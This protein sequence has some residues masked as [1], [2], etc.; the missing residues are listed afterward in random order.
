MGSEVQ[1]SKEKKVEGSEETAK[2][3][4]KKMLGRKRAE[5]NTQQMNPKLKHEIMRPLALRQTQRRRSDRGKVRRSVSSS[6]SYHQGTSS[7]QHDDDDDDDDFET[8]RANGISD[9]FGVKT[10]SCKVNA[11]RQD[12]VLMGENDTAEGFW[13]TTH[14]QPVNDVKQIHAT[15]DGNIVVISESSVRSDLYFNDEDG[16]ITPLFASMLTPPVVEGEGSGQPTKPQPAPSTTQPIIKEQIPV[17][18]SSSPQNTQ[19]PRQALQEDTQLPQT[20]VPIPNVVDEAV[21]KEC[22]DKVKLVQVTDP[23]AKKPWGVSLL[24][25]GGYTPRN[26]EGRPEFNE[27]IAICTKLYDRVLDLEKEK[28]AQA[29]EILKLKNIIK[30]LERKAKSTKLFLRASVKAVYCCYVI[31]DIDTLL[32]PS[33]FSA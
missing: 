21:F 3:S 10:G 13:N 2:S 9:E 4:R 23:G 12:L 1:E 6:S 20:S 14:S 25:L 19:T 22:D 33:K 29:V 15:I 32:G 18:E 26:D 7:R 5:K 30:K 28:D 27:L 11:A 8:S 24:R 17:T 31:P 16:R